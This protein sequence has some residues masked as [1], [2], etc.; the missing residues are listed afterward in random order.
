MKEVIEPTRSRSMTSR[1]NEHGAGS[2]G[3]SVRFM[4]EV[5]NKT[6]VAGVE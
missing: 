3:G 1:Q 4:F 2:S 6:G 5:I